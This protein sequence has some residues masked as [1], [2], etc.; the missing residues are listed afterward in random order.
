[1]SVKAVIFDWG[2]TLTPWHDID[3]ARMWREVCAAGLA[4]DEA[5]D[6]AE[7][8]N[9]AELELWRRGTDEH[10]SATLD[11]VFAVAGV[12]PSAALLTAVYELWTPHTL[13]DPAAPGLL[14]ELRARGVKVGVLSNT[15]WTRDWHERIFARD[16][17]LGLLDGAV[18]S[19]E[20]PW[21][22]PHAEAFRAAMAAVDVDDPSTCVFVGDRPFDDIHGAKSAGMR[23]ALM[24]NSTVP[25]WETEPDAVLHGGLGDLLPH[26]DRWSA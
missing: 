7:R 11:E 16:D 14:R 25:T 19:S 20:I 12:E 18:Y 21:T 4:P 3:I 2:G 5:A 26:I 8:L 1:M 22:K 23:A 10:R 9:A 15:M 13:I 24:P 6:A 17:V